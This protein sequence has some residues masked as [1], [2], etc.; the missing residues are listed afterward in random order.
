MAPSRPD[1]VKSKLFGLP[2]VVTVNVPVPTLEFTSKNTL[3]LEVGALAPDAPPE[4]VLQFVVV[5]ASH[6]PVPP[7]QYLSAIMCIYNCVFVHCRITAARYFD[8][9]HLNN[10]MSKSAIDQLHE[11]LSNVKRPWLWLLAVFCGYIVV[12][13]ITLSAVWFYTRR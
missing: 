8:L 4:E 9:L 3:S 5:E 7:T 1:A 11:Y 10:N 2:D 12:G 13:A 6:V